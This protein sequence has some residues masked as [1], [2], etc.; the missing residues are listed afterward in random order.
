MFRRTRSNA[1]CYRRNGVGWSIAY[2]V[3]F[4]KLIDRN[5]RFYFSIGLS[6][7]RGSNHSVPPCIQS[8][9]KIGLAERKASW[10]SAINV[11]MSIRICIIKFIRK[12]IVH[13]LE[14]EH[15][16]SNSRV[17]NNTE[18]VN[19]APTSLIEYFTRPKFSEVRIFAQFIHV[20]KIQKF[21]NLLLTFVA[22]PWAAWNIYQDIPLFRKRQR[23]LW[24]SNASIGNKGYPSVTH[25]GSDEP[26]RRYHFSKSA[27]L[28]RWNPPKDF[29]VIYA[30]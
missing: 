24:I 6:N 3:S 18:D 27:N 25:L 29:M 28:G 13:L 20:W 21:Q 1:A 12:R 2:S 14:R 9:Y 17:K 4:T 16:F 22:S 5:F 7:R 26:C 10:L 23:A 11:R 15:T 8:G 19:H 30:R